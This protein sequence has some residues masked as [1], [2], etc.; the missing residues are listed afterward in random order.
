VALRVLDPARAAAFYSGVLGL[1]LVKRQE[2]ESGLRSVWLRAGD[3][4]VMLERR[5]RGEG[6][7]TGSGHVLVF[8]VPDLAAAEE[9]LTREGTRVLDR[10]A[11]TL[12][13]HDPDGHRVGLSDFPFALAGR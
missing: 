4:V 11:H 5:L 8:A 6:A 9:R 7:E 1:A 2:D 3:V 12:Y 13:F 10:T